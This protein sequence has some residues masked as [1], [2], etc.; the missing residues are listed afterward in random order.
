MIA[1]Q[2]S[3]FKSQRTNFGRIAIPNGSTLTS[4]AEAKHA[5]YMN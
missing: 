3:L 4:T 1:K 5:D 2:E